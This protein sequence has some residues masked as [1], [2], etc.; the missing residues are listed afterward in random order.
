MR[1]VRLPQGCEER[2]NRNAGVAQTIMPP[3]GDMLFPGRCLRPIVS[4]IEHGASA[5]EADD[6]G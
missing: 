4:L 6:P 3:D 5:S 1:N 2:I